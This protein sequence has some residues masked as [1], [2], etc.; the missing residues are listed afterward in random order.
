[1]QRLVVKA[2]TALVRPF[3]TA[4]VLRGVTFD[5]V[6]YASFIDLQDKLHANLCR[7][8]SLVSMGTH[9]LATLQV[10]PAEMRLFWH[11]WH[12]ASR[13][14]APV[15]ASLA[16]CFPY[17]CAVTW[18][19]CRWPALAPSSGIPLPSC[20]HSVFVTTSVSMS[21]ACQGHPAGSCCVSLCG[22]LFS[23]ACIA[24]P[25]C[26]CWPT[27]LSR[28]AAAQAGAYHKA[29]DYHARGVALQHIL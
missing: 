10:W 25:C 23:V 28:P 22:S 4:A 11:H 3:V 8:R 19:R 24:W 16:S 27:G 2:E 13:T 6:R 18:P 26:R 12:L 29:L 20:M 9:D 1:M 5:P 17:A 7:Q 15:L 21:S 14:R